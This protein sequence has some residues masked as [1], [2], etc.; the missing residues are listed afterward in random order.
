MSIELTKATL[1]DIESM[2]KLVAPEVEAGVILARNSD[3]IA[4]NI[5]SYILAKEDGEIVGFC[6]LHIH[7]PLLAEIRSLIVKESKRG[8][9]IGQSLIAK[10]MQ[11][12]QTLGLKKVLTLTYKQSFF[13]KLG[14]VEIPK[15]SI[16][17]HKIW[18]DCIKC[19][20]FPICNE[21]SLIKTL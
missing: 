21:V 10:A 2:Q 11:E 7:T 18:A 4:T 19:K 13:E 1:S 17:E 14:F 5:R 9:G 15:E 3:E 20:L 6:A 8:M 12:A 16:P